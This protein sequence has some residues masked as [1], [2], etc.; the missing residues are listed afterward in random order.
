[1]KKENTLSHGYLQSILAHLL[2]IILALFLSASTVLANNTGEFKVES[3]SL[4]AKGMLTWITNNE[5]IQK[6]YTVQH[7]KWNKWIDIGTVSGEAALGSNEYT[8]DVFLHSGEN[9]IRI[10][11]KQN[12][13]KVVVLANVNYV[14][15]KHE[16]TYVYNKRASRIE[17]AEKTC[18]EVFDIYGNV[19]K[20]GNGTFVNM[21]E[22]P[23]SKI[24]YFCYDNSIAKIK[25]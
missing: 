2:L 20:K 17:F 7:Y 22:L 13:G 11:L 3:I 1:M 23:K 16:I 18:F 21:T 14:S 15:Q 8:F 4:S 9:K 10:V 5:H 25:R 19:I 12:K 24:Y 6:E